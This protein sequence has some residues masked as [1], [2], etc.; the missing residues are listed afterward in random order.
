[1]HLC[2]LSPTDLKKMASLF[3]KNGTYT[4]PQLNSLFAYRTCRAG[5]DSIVSW[6]GPA[7]V[8]T[9]MVDEED[10]LEKDIIKSL[11]M[12]HFVITMTCNDLEKMVAYQRLFISIIHSHLKNCKVKNVTREGDDLFIDERKLSVSI[13]TLSANGKGLIHI[14][15]NIEPGPKCPVAAAGF[16][17]DVWGI[18]PAAA[19]DIESASSRTCWLIMCMIDYEVNSIRRA[20]YKVR[21]VQ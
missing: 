21:D 6:H 13:S 2:Y 20:T 5:E 16:A 14:G 9:H 11:D 17:K 15:L 1:M 4:G 10:V 19:S 3:G 12:M 8:S 7:D 18:S